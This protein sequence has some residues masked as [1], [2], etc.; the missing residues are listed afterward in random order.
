MIHG[1]CQYYGAL[2]LDVISCGRGST[3]ITVLCTLMFFC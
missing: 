3:N 1:F 2:H